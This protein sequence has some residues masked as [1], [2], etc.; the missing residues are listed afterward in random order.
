MHDDDKTVIVYSGGEDNEDTGTI[1]NTPS[2]APE[3]FQKDEIA[4][5]MGASYD[6]PFTY[7]YHGEP[8]LNA[9]RALYREVYK[10]KINHTKTDAIALKRSLTHIMDSHTR[11]LAELGYENTHIMIV[12]YILSTFIDE[13]LGSV[14]FSNGEVWANQSLLSHYYKETY[15]GKKFF[16]LLEQFL[17]EPGKYL[18]HLKLIYACLSLGYQGKFSLSENSEIQVEN[19]RQELYARIKNYDMQE[20]KF[21]KGHPVSSKRHKLTLHVPYKLFIAGGIVILAI[22]YGIFTSMIA[23]NEDNLMNILKQ[24]ASKHIKDS[25]GN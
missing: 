17:Q 19:I 18:Q 14:N 12:R 20:E 3:R 8:F 22:I 15:G 9:L 4:A 1:V 7:G 11:T 6:M 5:H 2:E 23:T 16:Q 24:P 13:T 10:L 25:N 21:Y